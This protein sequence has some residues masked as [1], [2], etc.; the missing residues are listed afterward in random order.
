MENWLILTVTS[1][2][3]G[4]FLFINHRASVA[5]V[6]R[7]GD[8]IMFVEHLPGPVNVSNEESKAVKGTPKL[9]P[10][11]LVAEHRGCAGDAGPG[12]VE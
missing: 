11:G 8:R 12:G 7:A 3:A 1:F 9:M 2:R 6:A 10:P 4:P 5:G